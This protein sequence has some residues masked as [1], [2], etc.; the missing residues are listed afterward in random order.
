MVNTP[1]KVSINPALVTINGKRYAVAGRWLE[2]PLATTR[3]NLH[4][5]MV[6][7]PAALPEPEPKKSWKVTGSKGNLYK[8][9][10]E[11]GY[12]ICTCAGFGWRRRCKHIEGV[13]NEAR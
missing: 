7:E 10:L 4:R 3:E 8:V 2:V 1:I 5:Y 11:N 12:Y 13:K 9:K 6:W